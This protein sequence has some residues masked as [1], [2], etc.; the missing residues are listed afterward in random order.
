M[1]EG[2]NQEPALPSWLAGLHQALWGKKDLCSNI[3]RVADLSREDF[4][5]LQW[6]L[7]QDNP[8]RQQTP[9]SDV[10]TIKATLLRENSVPLSY[11]VFHPPDIPDYFTT[12]SSP[13]EHIR[14]SPEMPD[15]EIENDDGTSDVDDPIPSSDYITDAANNLPD[16]LFPYKLKYMDLTMLHLQHLVRVPRLMLIRDE[17]ATLARKLEAGEPGIFG[18][19]LVTGQPGIGQ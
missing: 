5:T 9:K 1:G 3:F 12:T 13:A 6:L 18:S 8:S 2:K 14:E 16:A 4:I 17:W 10:L 19:V 15:F 7:H 11:V